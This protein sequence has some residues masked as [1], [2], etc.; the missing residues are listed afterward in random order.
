MKK[1]SR[2]R[3]RRTFIIVLIVFC[4]FV[5]LIINNSEK[6]VKV[7]YHEFEDKI[8][9]KG[10][11]FVD[12]H[13]LY[14]GNTDEFKLQYKTGDLISKG[15]RISDNIIADKAGMIITH[16]DGYEN[17]YDKENIKGITVKEINNILYKAK[18]NPGIKIL[19]NS[20]WYVC[21]LLDQNDKKYFKKGMV[22]DVSINNRYYTAD[23]ID[24]LRND[25]AVI[26]VLRFKNDLD[27]E[28]LSRVI[29]GSII[30][31][32][33]EG[34]SIPEKSIID[35]NGGKGVFINLNGY[36]EFRKIS[37]MLRIDG[38]AIVKPERDSKP[39]LKEYD[40]IICNPDGLSS[41]KKIR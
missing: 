35:Y 20:Q 34:I 31:S 21:A 33:Y 12:E 18:N 7:A 10:F 16:I 37:V 6:T 9:F 29:K 19:D 5:Y 38:N 41:G 8:E 13:V 40:D 17:K 36:A 14:S 25:D 27:V 32:K 4:A 28:N 24:I 26:L 30:K 2:S 3:S 39:V 22:K 23:I 1:K 11:Y 15:T